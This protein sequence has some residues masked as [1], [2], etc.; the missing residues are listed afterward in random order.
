MKYFLSLGT[1]YQDAVYYNSATSYKQ[2]DFRTNID[3]KVSKNIDVAFDIAGR[4]EIRN[5]P[6]RSAGSIFRMLMRGK[7]NMPA[8]WPNGDPGPDIEY[9]DNPAV[10]TTSAT[11][12][13]VSKWYILESNLRININSLG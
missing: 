9:G 7:P 5:F 8:Y 2:Y 10:T 4:E 1:R 6:T 11:G 12:Y 13:D 3:G